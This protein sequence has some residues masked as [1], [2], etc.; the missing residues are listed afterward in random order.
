M[1][2]DNSVHTW[3]PQPRLRLEI[4]FQVTSAKL[5]WNESKKPKGIRVHLDSIVISHANINESGI[6]HLFFT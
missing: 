3:T 4:F 5:I 2:L 1:S 6:F